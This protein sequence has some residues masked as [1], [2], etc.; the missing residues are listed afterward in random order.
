MTEVSLS[1]IY[2]LTAEIRAIRQELEVSDK[3]IYERDRLLDE[4]PCKL[5]GR[6]VPHA[7]EEVRALRKIY[8]AAAALRKHWND[9]H[10][11]FACGGEA[12][13]LEAIADYEA[14]K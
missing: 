13:L 8:D 5:H 7:I 10:A 11:H 2:D 4:L 1:D 6:C 14:S 12:I 3:I 9:E